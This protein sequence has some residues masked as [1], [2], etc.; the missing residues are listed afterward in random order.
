MFKKFIFF[1]PLFAILS[2]CGGASTSGTSSSFTNYS[3]VLKTYPDSS[4]AAIATQVPSS[5]AGNFN[6]AMIALNT[7]EVD[8]IVDAIKLANDGDPK[9]ALVTATNNPPYY[10]QRIEGTNAIGEYVLL[11]FEGEMLPSGG[12][13]SNNIIAVGSGGG[14]TSDGSQL[15]SL[16][17]GTFTYTGFTTIGGGIGGDEVEDG[18]FNMQA[19]FTAMTVDISAQTANKFFT[20]SNLPINF[21]NG[22]FQGAGTIGIKSVN[23]AT[24]TVVGYFA[25][26][27]AEGVHGA[28]Y[29][30]AAVVGAMAGIFY[31]SR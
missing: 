20:G 27:Q 17:S 30:D 7:N 15:L 9:L 18:T 2:A 16:P 5:G 19:N 21:A 31:G 1:V 4:G 23:S 24:S 10:T 22:K 13:V 26:N 14:L 8:K 28:T 11:V 6:V 12:Y 25:G 3:E 29:Q